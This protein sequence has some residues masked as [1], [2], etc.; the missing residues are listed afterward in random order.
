M[1]TVYVLMEEGWEYNDEIYFQP[2]G[3]GAHLIHSLL[4]R[5]RP[6]QNAINE[7]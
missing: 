1:N 3:G 7:T 6:K 2:E 4:I 5:K